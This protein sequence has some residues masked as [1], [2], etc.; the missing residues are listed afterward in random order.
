M[1]TAIAFGVFDGLHPGHRAVLD[2]TRGYNRIAVT[3]KNLPK[4]GG[5]DRELLMTYKERENALLAIGIDKVEFLDLNKIGYMSPKDFLDYITNLFDVS[6]IAC[7]EN[8]RFGKFAAGDVSFLKEYCI[9]KKIE[10][11][12]CPPIKAD[13]TVISSSFIR[14]L[15]KQGEIER[16]N[17]YLYY[18]FYFVSVV[19]KG[20]QRGRVLGFPTLNQEIPNILVMPK[21]GVY[22]AFAVVNNKSYLAVTDIG[23]RPTYLIDHIAAETHILEFEGDLYGKEIKIILDKYL[24]EERKFY[25]QQELINAINKDITEVLQ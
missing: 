19:S 7:G 12:V 3:F 25:S 11:S 9:S 23:T 24:R 1:K 2:K 6:L 5:T 14:N 22:K 13:G 18:P 15:I 8:F 10:L 21:S 20:D 16:A 17:N 4:F